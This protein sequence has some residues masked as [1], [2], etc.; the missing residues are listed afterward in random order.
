MPGLR[1]QDAGLAK[2][3]YAHDSDIWQ[4]TKA[5]GVRR[6]TATHRSNHQPARYQLELIVGKEKQ[7]EL[8]RSLRYRPSQEKENTGWY[9]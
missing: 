8:C 9:R 5:T 2:Q 1:E 6:T 7:K 4:L 3:L